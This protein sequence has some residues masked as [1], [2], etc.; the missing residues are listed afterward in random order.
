[1]SPPGSTSS[2]LCS[3]LREG[4]TQFSKKVDNL[5]EYIYFHVKWPTKEEPTIRTANEGI[6]HDGSR[7]QES[8]WSTIGF[9]AL[10][11]LPRDP[12]TAELIRDRRR[13]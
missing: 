6:G 7:E 10:I 8:M 3:G 12:S 2:P 11:Y 5:S 13:T 1:M 4:A 9:S